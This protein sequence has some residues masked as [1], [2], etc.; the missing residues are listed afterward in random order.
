MTKIDKIEAV[1][2]A[3]K[4]VT[5]LTAIQICGAMRLAALI[6]DLKKRGL[7]ITTTIRQDTQGNDYAEYRMFVGPMPQA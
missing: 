3:G 7:K 5:P 1:L 4:K 6:F 2:K